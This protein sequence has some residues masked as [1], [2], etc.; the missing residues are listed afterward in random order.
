M[1][2][3]AVVSLITSSRFRPDDPQARIGATEGYAASGRTAGPVAARRRS[4]AAWHFGMLNDDARNAAIEAAIAALDLAG[5]TVLEIGTGAGLV[6][7]LFARHGARH[8]DSCEMNPELCELAR[9]VVAASDYAHKVSILPFS[10]SELVEKRH[11]AEPYDVI[12]TETLDCGV[13]GEG[14]FAIA[15]DIKRLAGPATLVLPGAVRQEAVLVDSMAM[16]RLNTVGTVRG[17]DLSLLNLY[18]TRAY[19]PV[20]PQLHDWR[21]LSQAQLVRCYDYL[22][23]S[24]PEPVAIRAR[25]NGTAHGLL[26]WFQA[27]L[28]SATMTNGGSESHWHQ[29]F[30]PFTAPIEVQAGDEVHLQL[31]DDGIASVLAHKARRRS[32]TGNVV[33]LKRRVGELV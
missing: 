28:G 15:D 14:F 25:Q 29:A 20:R 9:R 33:R 5:K 26:S 10:S 17:F 19:F 32:A 22:A 4:F 23:A 27:E 18:A 6:A 13:I 31:E 16:H 2:S 3:S 8:V 11:G 12:F 24:E 30:H 21:A 7:L 1:D